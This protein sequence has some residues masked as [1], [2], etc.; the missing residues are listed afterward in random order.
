MRKPED[1]IDSKQK[2]SQWVEMDRIASHPRWLETVSDRL[3]ELFAPNPILRFLCRLRKVEYLVNCK[4]G[5]FWALLRIYHTVR[6]RRLQQKCGY[7]IPI[8]VFGPGLS[9]SHRGPILVNSKVS[10]GSYC[11]LHVGVSIGENAGQP[12]APVIG[13]NVYIGPGAILFGPISIAD[14][15]WIGGNAT[16]IHSVAQP[17]TVVAGTP[18]VVVKEGMPNWKKQLFGIE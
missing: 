12:G 3:I 18:A 15:T 6:L 10:A 9:I 7:S 1:R 14:G 8:N 16:V 13:D 17:N 5:R 2:Y 11:R 4:Q